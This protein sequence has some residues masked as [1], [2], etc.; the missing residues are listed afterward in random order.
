MNRTLRFRPLTTALLALS[1]VFL[2]SGCSTPPKPLVPAQPYF[3]PGKP[4]VPRIQY[5]TSITAPEQIVAG[6]SLF[7]KFVLG[8]PARA[9]P[10]IKP[11]GAILKNGKLYACDTATVTIHIADLVNKTWNYFKPI[12]R[13]GLRKPVNIAVDDDGHIY[14]ADTL[15]E[16]VAIYRED[17]SMVNAIP[18]MK[19]TDVCVQGD[20]IF[21]T[22]F[23]THDVRVYDVNT[24]ELV[25]T[26]PSGDEAEDPV[27]GLFSPT[28]LDVDPRGHVYVSDAGAFRVQEYDAKG[29]YVR[30]YGA[31]G[32]G[33]GFFARNKGVG[34]D[35]QGRVYVADAAFDNVQIFSPDGKLLLFFGDNLEEGGSIALPA[36]LSIDYENVELFRSYFAP[37]MEMEYLI[38]VA[39][40][41][42]PHK[43]NVY[44]FIRQEEGN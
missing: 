32:K 31:Q 43:V 28:N 18:G 26:I 30:T 8:E 34:V 24:L 29:K 3:Y 23:K 21:V 14:V 13:D 42:G 39:S 35:D 9:I 2:F 33:P 1:G 19:A 36:G 17:G 25:K 40:Q 11:Y 5:L 37:G 6:P 20:K 10:L 22:S 41:Y 44:G 15:R 27:K 38:L 4:S 12:G 7:R 16:Q